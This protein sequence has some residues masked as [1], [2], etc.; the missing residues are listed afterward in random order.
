MS[1]EYYDD[2]VSEIN[3]NKRDDQREENYAREYCNAKNS[4]E[5]IE[6]DK[7]YEAYGGDENYANDGS[8]SSSTDS[9]T[10]L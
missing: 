6:V 5:Q 1:Q 4:K 3:D 2:I 7:E 8:T 9:C 10:I